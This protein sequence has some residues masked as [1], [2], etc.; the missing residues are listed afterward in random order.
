MFWIWIAALFALLLWFGGKTAGGVQTIRYSEFKQHL[1]RGDVLDAV[2]GETRITG[3]LGGGSDTGDE[4]PAAVRFRCVRLED[5]DLV[6][7]LES[8]GIPFTG[9]PRNAFSDLLFAWILPF[10]LMVLVLV[11]MWLFGGMARRAGGQMLGF[12]KSR[13]KL[14]AEE[15]TGVTFE[16]V[17]GCDEAKVELGQMVECLRNPGRFTALGG[18]I[19]KGVL[20]LGPPGTGKTLLARAI[21][22]EAG[23]PFFSLSGSEFV[24]M[25]V[26]VGAARVRDLFEQ[27]KAR[28]PC[29]VFIDEIDAIGRQ[30]G[31]SMGVVNDEREQTLNQLLAE[32]DGF[33]N[34]AGVILLAATNRPEILDRALLR[35]G[36]FDRQVVLDAP[37]IVG[38][39]AILAVHVRGKP[40][41]ADVELGRIARV[42]PGMAGADLANVV[43]EAALIAADRHAVEIAERD[44][45]EAV[46]RVVAGPE[47]RSRRLEPAE[48]RRVAYHE[49]GHAL[50]ASRVEHGDRVQKVTI[51]P[52]GRAALGYTMQLPDHEHYLRTKNE[53]MDRLAVLL[54]GRT[55]EEL[56]FADVSS[57][58]QDDLRGATDIARQ[59]VC[60]LGMSDR[61]GLGSCARLGEG[62]YLTPGAMVRD[63]SERTSRTIDEEV[64]ALLELARDRARSILEAERGCLE[65]IAQE[66]LDRETLDRPGLERI[67]ESGSASSDSSREGHSE[68]ACGT[69]AAI[70]PPSP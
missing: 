57:G 33:E 6:Q 12:G 15:G 32:M 46:E 53:L 41:A 37:D 34:N 55:A 58:A 36:R 61:V 35:P 54:G 56:V 28:A 51:V 30:R 5:A 9:A 65:R 11:L 26:G 45:L 52:R 22:G 7:D 66:L 17:A 2:V 62:A 4:V 64:R 40:L 44:L 39:E 18:R 20:L 38:R 21:A 59:M 19:P 23:V 48:K 14:V 68:E 3:K 13:A 69:S 16:D 42:T 10:G 25:F 63:C 49:S 67:L 1:A 24:E 70:A 47:R 50:V 60:L 8:A 43:N 29:I 27:A 31:I